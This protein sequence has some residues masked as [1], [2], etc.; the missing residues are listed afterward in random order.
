MTIGI[1]HEF[2]LAD[3]EDERLEVTV[4]KDGSIRLMWWDVVTGVKRTMRNL[5]IQRADF[6]NIAATVRAWDDAPIRK[7]LSNA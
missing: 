7:G 2:L 6:E 3:T 5:H 4:E 1:V